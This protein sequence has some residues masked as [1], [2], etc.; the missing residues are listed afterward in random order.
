M[1]LL[2]RDIYTGE[3]ERQDP[4]PVGRYWVDVFDVGVRKQTWDN[5]LESKNL[6]KQ[7]VRLLNHE[8]FDDSWTDWNDS[9]RDWYLFE[10][11]EPVSWGIQ[12]EVG[13]PTIAGPEVQTSDDT[14]SK[15]DPVAEAESEWQ[16]VKY[17][18]FGLVGVVGLVAVAKIVRG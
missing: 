7:R 15:P 6:D 1:G 12:K 8:H 13:W 3:L 10:V 11:L 18:A 9:D 16:W 14:V 5:W 17:A 2:A 4:V